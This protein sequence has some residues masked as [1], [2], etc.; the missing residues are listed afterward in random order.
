MLKTFVAS[1]CAALVVRFFHAGFAK[2]LRL[3]P[4]SQGL[5]AKTEV[6]SHQLSLDVPQKIDLSKR[7]VILFYR[8]LCTAMESLVGGYIYIY[9]YICIYIYIYIRLWV[10]VF[11]CAKSFFFFFFLGGGEVLIYIYIY[12]CIHALYVLKEAHFS[13]KRILP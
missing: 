6:P 4:A 1:A 12:V 7:K 5:K 10:N 8:G 3:N 2:R 13:L 9:V 11:T